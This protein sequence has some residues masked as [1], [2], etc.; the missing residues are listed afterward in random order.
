MPIELRL[1]VYF[2]E[3][4]VI[5]HKVKSKTLTRYFLLSSKKLVDQNKTKFSQFSCGFK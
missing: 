2:V 5:G 1:G 3:K 4:V